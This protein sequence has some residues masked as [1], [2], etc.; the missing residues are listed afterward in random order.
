MSKNLL[1]VCAF[2]A[3]L[4]SA[5]APAAAGDG[6]NLTGMIADDT[7]MLMV[8]DVADARD[9]SLLQKGYQT[10]L[11][12]TPDAKDKL[13][14]LG[15]D[16]FADIDTVLV[17]GGG[18]KDFDGFDNAR[19]MTLIVEGRLPRDKVLAR[20]R[21]KAYRGV[22]LV[23]DGDTEMAFIGDRLFLTKKGK[24]KAMIDVALGKGKGK[25]K[26]AGASAKAKKLRAALAN[27]D[28][29]AD[30]WITVL[31]PDKN[32]KQMAKDG[33]V[34]DSIS[35]GASFDKDVALHVRLESGSEAAAQ[36]LVGLIQAQLGQV[37]GVFDQIGL[38]K[39]GRSLTVVQD[40]SAVKI[41]MRLTEAEIK[42]LMSTVGGLG[43][44]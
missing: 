22:D 10:I 19:T 4:I 21:A 7:Q 20:G 40:Q 14:E 15:V 2:G 16:L 5:A 35:G 12:A 3:A 31:V 30:V 37:T 43:S 13:D 39:A 11:A 41:A 18:V 38:G 34:F 8:F 23:S 17:A 27:T 25:G 33:M 44:P 28:T 32:K 42:T 26:N 24:G 9:S 6:T 29:T 1:A 36:K